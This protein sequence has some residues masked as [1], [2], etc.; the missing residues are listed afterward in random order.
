M[1]G[2]SSEPCSLSGEQGSAL[3]KG[4]PR[5]FRGTGLLCINFAWFVGKLT[6]LVSSNGLPWFLLGFVGR[7]HG[8]AD[9]ASTPA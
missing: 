7:V 3:G 4:K 6:S 5:A 2:N 9:F 1:F 8:L